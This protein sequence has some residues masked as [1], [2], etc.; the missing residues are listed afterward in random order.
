MV[1]QPKYRGFICTTAH[2]IGCYK[3]VEDMVQA[4]KNKTAQ[5]KKPKNVLVLGCSGGYGLASRVVAAFSYGAKTVGVSFEKPSSGKRTASAGFYN[6]QAFDTL[7]TQ[8]GLAHATLN[9]DAFSNE[10]K[11][12][13]VATCKDVFDGEP[14]DLLV[15]S[16]AAPKRVDPETG[17]VYS[18]VIKPIGQDFTNKTVDFHTGEL[19]TVTVT[20]ATEEEIAQTVQVMGGVDWDLWVQR[21]TRENMLAKDCM[22]VSYSYIGPEVTHAIYKDGTIGRA[23]DDLT[24]TCARIN[25]Q[26]AALG[27]KAYVSVNKALVTQASAAIPV[28]PLYIS[29]LYKVMKEK[30]L[31][32]GCYEQMQRLFDERLYAL[33]V[34]AVDAENRIR[35][36]DWEMQA[37]VQDAVNAA[38]DELT[39]EKVERM[40]DLQGFRD[41]FFAIFG[42]G[43]GD[44]DYEADVAEF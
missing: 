16:L 7:A 13:V 5:G 40:T 31:H 34:P 3:N 32:E 33:G 19:G 38:W 10:M 8:E 2:P 27:G 24:V 39:T 36:D 6:N 20:A 22:T 28:V 21:L 26:L 43:R 41:D 17:E 12:K 30:G 42:F 29:L 14:I 37:E 35:M 23:K 15:Y 11:D 4:A 25:E 9:G 44:V 1:I 18:S